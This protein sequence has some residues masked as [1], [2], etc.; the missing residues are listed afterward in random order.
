[1]KKNYFIE[2]LKNAGYAEAFDA[3]VNGYAVLPLMDLDYLED[4]VNATSAVKVRLQS[5]YGGREEWQVFSRLIDEIAE[6]YIKVMETGLG[7]MQAELKEE[8]YKKYSDCLGV[9][10]VEAEEPVQYEDELPGD[11]AEENTVDFAG[12]WEY[13]KN[14]IRTIWQELS[15]DKRVEAVRYL[16]I[17]H[18][19]TFKGNSKMSAVSR[20]EIESTIKSL[21]VAGCPGI[22]PS[23]DF[24]WGEIIEDHEILE[25]FSVYTDK[26]EVRMF[27][28]NKGFPSE[29]LEDVGKDLA[30]QMA[31]EPSPLF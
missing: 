18:G 5:E 15:G 20:E 9:H 12:V 27:N 3:I 23:F 29:A 21:V 1:M 30:E 25:R 24:R 31:K 10:I 17:S 26:A 14:A 6:Y 19:I 13:T 22:C 28:A 2:A 4:F 7:G 16:Y 11:D 8:R